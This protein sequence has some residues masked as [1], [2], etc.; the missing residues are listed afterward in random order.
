MRGSG[1]SWLRDAMRPASV[2]GLLEC[3][4]LLPH[5]CLGFPG[6]GSINYSSR[7]SCP[8]WTY[9]TNGT[10]ELAIWSPWPQL[11]TDAAPF[12]RAAANGKPAG[13]PD[14]I[15]AQ[16]QACKR[17]LAASRSGVCG[18]PLSLASERVGHGE[19]LSRRQRLFLLF[20]ESVELKQFL[21]SWA[22]ARGRVNR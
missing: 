1:Q 2:I 10:R 14:D 9:T 19:Q 21:L 3:R 7:R 20:L 13:G 4:S 17:R 8:R 6:R 5:V 16:L 18:Q 11:H 12:G 15:G 22:G